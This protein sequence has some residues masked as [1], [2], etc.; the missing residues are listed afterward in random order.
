MSVDCDALVGYGYFASKNAIEESMHFTDD[1]NFWDFL[2]DHWNN[3]REMSAY[4]DNPDVFIGK[5]VWEEDLN[6]LVENPNIINDWKHE[7]YR[8]YKRIFGNSEEIPEPKFII[9]TYWH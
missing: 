8:M 7:A 1:Y 4:V 5:K 2:D 9:D 3:L 6:K